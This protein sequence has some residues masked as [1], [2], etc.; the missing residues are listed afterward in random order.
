M[1]KVLIIGYGT[2]GHNL[3]REIAALQPDIF[4]KYKP[5]E[6]TRQ[7]GERY[8]A[9]FVCVDTPYIPGEC[10]CDTREVEN[11]ILENDADIFVVKS[12]VLPG[13]VD[14]LKKVTGKTVIF[15]PEYYG[16]TQHC[17][18]FDFPFTIL[19]GQRDDCLKAQ[20]ILQR[21]YD[22][23]HTF[24]ITDAKTAEL[25]KYMENAFLATKVSFC[26]QFWDTAKQIGVSYEELRE[27]FTLDPRVGKSHTFVYDETPFWSSHCLDKDVPAIA[28]TFEMPFLL[29]VIE[30]NERMKGKDIVS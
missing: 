18:N 1:K 25:A 3:E 21:V 22:G 6:N 15:S 17:N 26:T 2:V 23:R 24:R 9:A 8:D 12:T 14:H 19:G 7:D 30:F 29:S 5:D 4:D 28:E 20:Q 13:T 11:A 10:V 16:G 27:L